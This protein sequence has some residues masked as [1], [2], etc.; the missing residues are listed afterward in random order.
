MLEKTWNNFFGQFSSQ[1]KLAIHRDRIHG[2]HLGK[3]IWAMSCYCI[4]SG[5]CPSL[6]LAPYMVK[7]FTIDVVFWSWAEAKYQSI[8][9]L[10]ITWI[11]YIYITVCY[12]DRQYLKAAWVPLIGQ[13]CVLGIHQVVLRIPSWD[14]VCV[15]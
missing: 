6:G 8:A 4:H 14:T 2:F 11:L 15:C 7:G 1:Y 10:C 5:L 3:N 9:I 13:G 12:K